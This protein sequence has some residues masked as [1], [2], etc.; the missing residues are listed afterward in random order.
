MKV[1]K[2]PIQWEAKSK[3][4]DFSIVDSFYLMQ[5]VIFRILFNKRNVERYK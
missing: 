3:Q 1:K 5:D 4:W 2:G